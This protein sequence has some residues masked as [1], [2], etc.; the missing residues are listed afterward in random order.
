MVFRPVCLV[1]PGSK[2][3]DG[4]NITFWYSDITKKVSTYQAV[5]GAEHRSTPHITTKAKCLYKSHG[6][7]MCKNAELLHK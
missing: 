4:I 2:V 1:L 6:G 7:E 3:I 5:N